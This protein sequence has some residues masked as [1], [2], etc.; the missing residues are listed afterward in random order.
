MRSTSLFG[1]L[2]AGGVEDTGSGE[3]W[4]LLGSPTSGEV[5]LWCSELLYELMSEFVGVVYSAFPK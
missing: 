3:S 5:G 1:L 4:N 2:W